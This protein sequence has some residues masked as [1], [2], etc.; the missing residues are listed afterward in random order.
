MTVV[1]ILENL[2][3]VLLNITADWMLIHR[4]YLIWGSKKRV[5]LGLISVIIQAVT[6]TNTS[7]DSN[8]SLYLLGSKLEAG[9]LIGSAIVNSL[10]TLLTV[11]K[12]G[13]IWWIHRQVRG[14][15]VQSSDRFIQRVSAIM[16][17]YGE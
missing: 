14:H 1:G 16:P 7:T 11:F 3:S 15:G 10:I 8:S 9:Y 17:D 4:C 2:S 6:I 13:R 5:G 12:A